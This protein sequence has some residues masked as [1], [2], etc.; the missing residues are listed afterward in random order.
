MIGRSHGGQFAALAAAALLI[1]SAS[2]CS[3]RVPDAHWSPPSLPSANAEK[4]ASCAGRTIWLVVL[5]EESSRGVAA[6]V[7]ARFAAS[8]IPHMGRMV[9]LDRTDNYEGLTPGKWVAAV[10]CVERPS[11]RIDRFIGEFSETK[12]RHAKVRVLTDL[13][14]WVQGPWDLRG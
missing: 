8:R 5:S 7:H 14:L 10:P 4:R 13:P 11:D 9:F 1:L 2:A 3:P 6:G 12:V